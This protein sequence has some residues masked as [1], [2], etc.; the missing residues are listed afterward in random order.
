MGVYALQALLHAMNVS[1]NDVLQMTKATGKESVFPR[2]N[3]L[4]C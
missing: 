1:I 3:A 2:M 4:F